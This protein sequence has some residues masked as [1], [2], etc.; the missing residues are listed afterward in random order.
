MRVFSA[1]S[2]DHEPGAFSTSSS[3]PDSA[4]N[5]GIAAAIMRSYC[6]CASLQASQPTRCS[7]SRAH[8]SA[9]NSP[10]VESAQSF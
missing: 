4:A 6:R 5:A 9:V 10:V 3:A 2:I 8:S 1:S 7:L